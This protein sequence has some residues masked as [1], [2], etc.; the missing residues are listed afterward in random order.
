M[1]KFI[2]SF[3]LLA[4]IC[5]SYVAANAQSACTPQEP[6]IVVYFDKMGTERYKDSPGPGQIDIVYVFGEGFT[7]YVSGVQYSIDYGSCLGWL[8]DVETPGA[9][10]G[11]SPTGIAIGFGTQPRAGE[12]FLIHKAYVMWG[13][14]VENNVDGPVVK[15]HPDLGAV[16]A[17]RFPDFQ[18]I[19]AVGARSQ[20]NQLVGLDIKPGSCR[21]TFKLSTDAHKKKSGVLSVAI[22]GSPTVN[23]RSIDPAS[24]RLEG[25]AASTKFT[26]RDVASFYA[27][28]D[29]Q[30]ELGD[31][32]K[33]LVLKFPAEQLTEVIPAAEPGTVVTL[34]MTGCYDDGMPFETSDFVTLGSRG[35]RKG[36]SIGGVGLG[37]PNPNPFNP[38]TR[39]SYEVSETQHVRLAIY[40]VAG[41]LV[42]EL[43]NEVKNA[44]EYVVEWDAGVLPSGVYFYRLQTGNETMVRRATLLK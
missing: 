12:K 22:L 28:G 43:V 6:Q 35:P 1:N 38:V 29:T 8:G 41:R 33:D 19:P 44:G 32:I 2:P 40:D 21:N 5:F 16:A 9:T 17:T 3:L 13:P 10:I 36:R 34:A 11:A 30:C 37:Y 20:S 4:L 31:G 39:I 42:E 18:I 7:G 26:I 24:V 25:V 15:D 23:V 14:C 27:E